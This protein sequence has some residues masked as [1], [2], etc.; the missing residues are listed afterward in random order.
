MHVHM[1]NITNI[2]WNTWYYIFFVPDNVFGRVEDDKEVRMMKI[3]GSIEP[4]ILNNITAH[5]ILLSRVLYLWQVTLS[6]YL[7]KN[8]TNDSDFM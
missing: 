8:D 2:K 5:K 1:M 3:T 6:W 4:I 7:D